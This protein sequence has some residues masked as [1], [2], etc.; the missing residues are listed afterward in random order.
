MALDFPSSPTDGQIYGSYVY[1][2]TI[3]VWQSKEESATVAVTS[4]T[5]P[6]TANNGDIWYNSSR[7]IP[8]VYY[9]DG[10]SSQWV[11]IITSGTPE[12]ATK[13]DLT[14]P[15][16]S[17]TVY[18][19]ATTSI[20][21]ISS[22]EISYLDGATS[23]VQT[24]I[25]SKAAS[26]HNHAA[27]D[28]ASGRLST[29]LMPAG[30]V[31]QVKSTTI[32]SA[33]TYS[34]GSGA[35]QDVGVNVSITPTSTSSKILVI[36]TV[37]SAGISFNRPGSVLVRNGTRIAAGDA[38][39][40]RN[41]TSSGGSSGETSPGTQT[42]NFLDSPATTSSLTYGVYIV[43]YHSGTQSYA[44]NYDQGNSDNPAHGRTA[45]TITVME[46]AG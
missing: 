44:F 13:A 38:A 40:S 15:S 26:S 34:L 4:P 12:L 46:I 6:L 25:N 23:N 24:Q 19:P 35:I 14:S 33:A 37:S 42:V 11:E 41:R 9:D 1:N 10:T 7:G 43:N 3:G 32:S 18:L 16:F 5:K 2:N 36:S 29:S 22:T 45:S 8:Y 28:I 31:L 21:N 30:T 27:S 17:G 20:G 39:G